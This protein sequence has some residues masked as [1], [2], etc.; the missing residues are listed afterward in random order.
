M[1]ENAILDNLTYD[2]REGALRYKGVRY[3]LIRPETL[4]ELLKAVEPVA[5]DQAGEA[6]YR[7]GFE[8]GRLST[9][10]YR[11]IH[12]FSD[13]EIIDFMMR[14]GREIGWGRLSLESY[15]PGEGLLEVRVAG[16]AFAEAYGPS[17]RPVCHLIRGV[18]AGMG[19]ALLGRAC[20]GLEP[21]CEAAGDPCC[22][23]TLAGE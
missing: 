13:R 4:G 19:S 9:E 11:E 16:S 17:S 7:G 1:R 23:F 3:L 14:M 12:G 2:E 22:R 18:V 21:S 15:R 20:R 10:T 6:L 5:G 8:G